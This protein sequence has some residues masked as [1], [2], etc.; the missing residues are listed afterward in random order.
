[1]NIPRG[2]TCAIAVVLG[3]GSAVCLADTAAAPSED[4]VTVRQRNGWCVAESRN[5]SCWT[6]L[7]AHRARELAAACETWRVRLQETWG[8]EGDKRDWIPRCE[9]VVHSTQSAY[10]AAL[11]RPGDASVGSTQI[12]Y[13]VERV[14][15]RRVDLRADAS[16]WANAALPHELTHVVL[17]E[18]FGGRPLPAWADEG[19]AMLSESPAKRNARLAD[20][21]RTLRHRPTY[22]I[23]ELLSV[24]QLPAPQRRDAFYGQSLALTS[25]LVERFGPRDFA[26]FLESCQTTTVDEALRTE[27]AISGVDGLERDWRQWTRSPAALTIVDLWEPSGSSLATATLA[28]GD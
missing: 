27:F 11:A 25:R 18:R 21:R 5:F 2:W 20:L 1:V 6:C 26:R 12:R 15:Q 22:S 16:D 19:L 23:G 10:N 14:V 9:I 8:G 7:E 28:G 13:D 24:R 3:T 17:G 4:S